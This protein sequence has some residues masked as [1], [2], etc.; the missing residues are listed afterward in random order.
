M[1]QSP[2][3]LIKKIEGISKKD[4]DLI[5]EAYGFAESI[6]GNTKRYSGEPYFNHVF[7]TAKTITEFGMSP[8]TV[9]AGLLHD[10]IEDEGVSEEEIERRFGKDVLFL[11]DGVTKLGKVRFR[12]AERHVGSLQ[13]LFLAT[14]KDIRV[15]IIKLADRLHNMK[16]LKY[17]PDGKRVRIAKETMEV[18]A[19]I[20][21]RL[22]MGKLTGELQDL[23]FPYIYP[24]DYE[25][26]KKLAE[27]KRAEKNRSLSK[28]HK[29]LS[30]ELKKERIHN[31]QTDYRL[32]HL[33]SIYEKLKRKDFD[34]DRVYDISALRVLVP[35]VSDC[36]KVLG[37]VHSIWR[38]LP[39]RIKDYIAFPKPNGYQSIHT[40]IFT[41]EGE[42]AEIQIR[43]YKMHEEAEF[44]IA[45]HVSYKHNRSDISKIKLPWFGDKAPTKKKEMP[46]EE[47]PE[48]VREIASSEDEMPEIEEF[49]SNLKF[50]FFRDRIFVF[51]P[52]GDVVDL[53]VDSSP[54]D[55][56]YR[57]HT[58]VGNHVFGVKVNGK[59][60]SLDEKL[61]NGD[62]V[63]VITK[64]KSSPSRKWLEYAHTAFAKR[65]I[66]NY[67]QKNR[68]RD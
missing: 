4:A 6:H 49:Y 60:V 68:K 28:M 7:E 58:D 41:G 2:E 9:I 11:V 61:N 22:G 31:V 35:T 64:E 10:S 66:K 38:P 62:I 32:K 47:I 57:I 65:H 54:I 3:D 51:T 8:D 34:I 12:G 52:L 53:P 5:R 21:H 33:Y 26:V 36:Y 39:G 43:T 45:S 15:L 67:I 13:K 27:P 40:T 55:F 48:W 44:G 25:K 30:K 42:I 24:E 23:A 20:A 29:I 16:T 37:I 17:V 63:E 46:S 59:M 1:T 19:P 56:A 14:T 50:D 18:Y